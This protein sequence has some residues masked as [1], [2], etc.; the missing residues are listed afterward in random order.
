LETPLD[1]ADGKQEHL[2]QNGIVVLSTVAS[3]WGKSGL[4]ISDCRPS[5]MKSV[6]DFL[7]LETVLYQFLSP[8]FDFIILVIVF[9]EHCIRN[10]FKNG[11]SCNNHSAT[12]G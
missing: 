2:C 5:V 1:T 7:I 12:Y 3:V 10:I 6:V 8:A 11:I 4:R 9:I